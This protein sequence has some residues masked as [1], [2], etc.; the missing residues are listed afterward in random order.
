MAGEVS[1]AE[2][3]A[4]QP[5]YT[6]RRRFMRWLIRTVGFGLLARAEIT[7]VENV[8]D[9]GPAILMMNHI[10]LIDPVVCMGAVTKRFVVPMTKVENVRNPF[11]GVFV[12]MWGAYS[13]DR[14]SVDRRALT[15]SIELLKSG[16]LILIA[17]EG[18][19]HPEGLARPKE[20]MTYVAVRSNAV[21]VPAALSDSMDVLQRW[22]RLRPARVRLTFG[23]PF[24]FRT[25][26]RARIPRDELSRMTEEAMYQ[27]AL[28]QPD[29]ALRGVYADLSQATTETL[30]F[31][32]PRNPG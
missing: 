14:D 27:L 26:G 11:L 31:I 15:N 2:Y 19:R 9:S 10:S 28:A 7:G 24:R 18:T 13:V 5:S 17:P 12:R 32:D 3:V 6:G 1:V 22:K 21:I 29:P 23:R 4:R 16:Q 25:E 30:E 8:P 20:G